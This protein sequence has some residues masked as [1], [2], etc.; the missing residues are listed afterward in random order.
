MPIEQFREVLKR[1]WVPVKLVGDA[2]PNFVKGIPEEIL[3]LVVASGSL[4]DSF[5]N[6]SERILSEQL[7]GGIDVYR[8][9]PD[10]PVEYNKDWYSVVTDLNQ[11]NMV[12]I[13]GP[14]KDHEH[15]LDEIPYRFE[16]IEVLGV[17]KKSE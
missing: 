14:I 11:D 16:G 6:E 12:L 3:E 7:I 2:L 10:D 1:K 5:S 15:W 13:K 4:A 17:P 9:A 8:K